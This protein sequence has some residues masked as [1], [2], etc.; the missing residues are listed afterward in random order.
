MDTVTAQRLAIDQDGILSD[1]HRGGYFMSPEDKDAVI[2]R[3]LRQRKEAKENL[4][5]LAAEAKRIG[6]KLSVLSGY[7]IHNPHYVWFEATSTNTKYRRP[8]M[9]ESF[10]LSDFDSKK[11]ADLTTQIRNAMDEVERLNN[12]AGKLGY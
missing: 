5:T 12:E 1:A 6:E 11:I 7:L 2:G 3:V 9:E 4:A 8:G 10:R